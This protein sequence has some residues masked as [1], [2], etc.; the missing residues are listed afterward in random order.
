MCIPQQRQSLRDH[1]R[2]RQHVR[3]GVSW[4]NVNRGFINPWPGGCHFGSRLCHLPM[5]PMNLYKFSP[6]LCKS[7]V[8]TCYELKSLWSSIPYWDSKHSGYINPYENGL[9][10][11]PP[12]NY[13]FI[14]IQLFTTSPISFYLGNPR[15]NNPTS[16]VI[17]LSMCVS[18]VLTSHKL[19]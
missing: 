4:G 2:P 6:F 9:T 19:M 14:T 12:N 18:S 5:I 1:V 7:R 3:L 15:V 8:K 10:T 16:D 11:I 13:F 17:V